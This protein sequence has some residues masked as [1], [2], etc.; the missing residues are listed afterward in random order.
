MAIE[1]AVIYVLTELP[2]LAIEGA[3]L[4]LR[5]DISAG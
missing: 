4:V 3:A 2:A 1:N 5:V